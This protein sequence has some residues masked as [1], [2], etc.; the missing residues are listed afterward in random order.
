MRTRGKEEIEAMRSFKQII[1]TFAMVASLALGA[2]AQAVDQN[3]QKRP[4]K[5]PP[6]IDPKD[7]PPRDNPPRGNDKPPKKPGMSF[8]LV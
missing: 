7:K 1:F 8:F 2:S 5:K 3:D 6:V 4:P